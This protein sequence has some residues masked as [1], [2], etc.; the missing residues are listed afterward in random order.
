MKLKTTKTFDEL[1]MSD[2]RISVFQ[3]GARS[4]KTYNIVF[5]LIYTALIIEEPDYFTIARKTLPA[6][7]ASAL[8][9]FIDILNRLNRYSDS[10]FNK[11][12]LEYKLNGSIFEFISLDQP[13]KIKSRKRGYL[14]LPEATEDDYDS[15][16]QLSIRT[17]K[18]I[19]L[20]YNPAAEYHWIYDE[21]LT[22]ED[23]DFYHSTYL[24][25]PFL[26]PGIIAEIER[27]EKVDENF[28]KIYGLGERGT[29]E[30]LVF[31]KWTIIN[32]LPKGE[33]F[34]GLDFGFTNDPTAFV[35][36]I[37]NKHAISVR[38]LIYKRGLTNR[39]IKQEFVDL[40]ISTD[41][42]IIAD[43]A[44]PKSIEEL[45]QDV[46][47]YYGYYVNPVSKGPDSIKKGIDLIKQ[48]PLQITS[49]SVNLIKELRNYKWE[50]KK[51]ERGFKNVPVDAFNH[52]ID[53]MRY[54]CME[55]I[56]TDEII[57]L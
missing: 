40:N 3:G 57:V 29:L 34:Y 50:K 52:A 20:D 35:E 53:A 48:Y 10:D 12:D 36:I 37:Y 2:K 9:D 16:V 42:S 27:L 33:R 55:N 43:S 18:K 56:N 39:D 13:D 14:F 26:E 30:G 17:T 45:S 47:G 25:N 49:D 46:A 6:L 21:V 23:H 51:Q 22:R 7:K 19:I 41:A 54:G 15:W 38:E 4:G 32:E 24:D 5:W 31:Q 11:S 44:E 8:R 28:W 1:C